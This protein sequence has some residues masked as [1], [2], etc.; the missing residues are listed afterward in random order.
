MKGKVIATHKNLKAQ[1]KK[2]QFLKLKGDYEKLIKKLMNLEFIKT[3]E[4]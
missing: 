2:N 3:S 1:Y 4:N